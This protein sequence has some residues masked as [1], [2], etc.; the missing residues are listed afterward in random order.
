M[1]IWDSKALEA[2][3]VIRPPQLVATSDLPIVALAL[4]PRTPDHLLLVP[5]AG[6]AYIMTHRGNI[7]KTLTHG[8]KTPP[9]PTDTASGTSGSGG[10]GAS[11]RAAHAGVS[12]HDFVAAAVSPQG[13]WIYLGSEDNCVYVFSTSSGRLEHTLENVSKKELLGVTHHPLRNLLATYGS[14]GTLHLWKP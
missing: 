3:H 7:L 8:L 14:D 4:I 9:P 11:H 13:K 1:R 2:I 5:R 10:A 6:T 12:T